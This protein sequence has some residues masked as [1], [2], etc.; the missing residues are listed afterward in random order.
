MVSAAFKV[1]EASPVGLRDACSRRPSLRSTNH[2]RGAS[3]WIAPFRSAASRYR[4]PHFV[5]RSIT[6]E[7]AGNVRKTQKIKGKVDELTQEGRGLVERGLGL[8]HGGHREV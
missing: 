6:W 2:R 7:T 5:G 3:R 4:A 1:S 8:G